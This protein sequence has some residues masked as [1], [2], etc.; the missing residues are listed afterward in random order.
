MIMSSNACKKRSK[1]CALS[2]NACCM[3]ILTRRILLLRMGISLDC[4]RSASAE[5]LY[6]LIYFRVRIAGPVREKVF[7]MYQ[8][9]CLFSNS[10][11]MAASLWEA[12]L[13]AW[14]QRYC[15]LLHKSGEN[16]VPNPWPPERSSAGVHLPRYRLLAESGAALT[17]DI[18]PGIPWAWR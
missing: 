4:H 6:E 18:P 1:G 3:V 17:F 14:I 16:A 8:Y 7:L 5:S 12:A 2:Q 10:T 13:M 15:Y 9:R 11:K